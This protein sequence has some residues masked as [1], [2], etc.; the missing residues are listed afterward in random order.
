MHTSVKAKKKQAWRSGGRHGG[1][2]ESSLYMLFAVAK[3]RPDRNKKIIS[4]SCYFSI[5]PWDRNQEVII[6]KESEC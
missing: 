3:V 6:R 4:E 5:A 1:V 2:R